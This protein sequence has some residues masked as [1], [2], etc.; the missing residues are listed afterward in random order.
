MPTVANFRVT[1][2]EV[3]IGCCRVGPVTSIGTDDSARHETVTLTT[4][5]DGSRFLWEWRQSVAYGA[6]D[7]RDVTIELLT[8]D[9]EARVV[10]WVLVGAT[11]VRWTGPTLDAMLPTT[12]AL[13]EVELAFER[14]EWL[15]EEKA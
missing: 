1:V 9:H 5:C 14:V 8:F 11:P 12:V 13:E 2:G 15:G 3:E 10:G 4:D 7:R 6:A